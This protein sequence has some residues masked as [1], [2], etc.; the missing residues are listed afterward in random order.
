MYERRL[1]MEL[2]PR[3]SST[4]SERLYDAFA[5]SASVSATE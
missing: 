2:E 4:I 3:D 5:S 1:L